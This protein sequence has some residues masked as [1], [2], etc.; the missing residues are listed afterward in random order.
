MPEETKTPEKTICKIYASW[1]G[2][3]KALKEPWAKFEAEVEK[4]KK[5]GKINCEVM[6]IEEQ[7]LSG[8]KMETLT[9][10]NGGT[11]VEVKGFPTITKI[12]DNKLE[13]Y[14]G[15]RT[16]DALLEWAKK[17]VKPNTMDGGRRSRQRRRTNKRRTNRRT[18]RTHRRT[19]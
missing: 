1:C 6:A 13:Y 12:Q 16:A 8:E 15:E 7:E 10:R 2:H 4:L 17:D 18:R 11:K 9:K 5:E 14:K 19:R 3:C